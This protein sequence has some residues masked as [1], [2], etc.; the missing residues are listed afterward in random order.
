MFAVIVVVA[1]SMSIRYTGGQNSTNSDYAPGDTRIVSHSSIFCQSITLQDTSST[2]ATLYLLREKPQLTGHDSFTVTRSNGIAPE[3]E[4]HLYYYLYPGSNFSVSTW[5]WSGTLASFYLIKG[6]HNFNKWSDNPSSYYALHHFDIT[7]PCSQG[8]KNYTSSFSIEDQYYFVLYNPSDLTVGF[9]ATYTFDRVLYQPMNSTIVDSC[10]AG[11]L[12]SLSSS[13]TL[14]V[15]YQSNYTALIVVDP[16]TTNPDENISIDT[17][18]GARVWIYVVITVVPV[19]F[20]VLCIVGIVVACV[21]VKKHRKKVYEP[22][23]T[24]PKAT[25]NLG[26]GNEAPD[27]APPPFNPGYGTTEPPPEYSTVIKQ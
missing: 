27:Y 6:T 13:C 5:L 7:S 15:P 21:L 24:P 18:C 12:G 23:N 1:V 20:V 16:P 26:S 17:S 3:Y 25:A 9:D 2:A 14:D 4:N 10:K 22:L 8:K 19:L 11:G